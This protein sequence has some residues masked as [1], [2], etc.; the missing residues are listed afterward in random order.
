[1]WL[2]GRMTT[3]AA[4]RYVTAS[5]VEPG[6]LSRFR[7]HTSGPLNVAMNQVREEYRVAERHLDQR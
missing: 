5:A 2:R 6:L 4:A 1:M 7:V 3:G